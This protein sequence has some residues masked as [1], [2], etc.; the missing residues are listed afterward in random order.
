[1]ADRDT[2]RGLPPR[3]AGDDPRA[4]I[5]AGPAGC[6]KSTLGRALARRVGAALLDQDTLTNPLVAVVASLPGTDP[7]DLDAPPVRDR[8]RDARYD[9][10]LSVA[11]DNVDI[12]GSVVLVAPFT[13][14]T[15]EQDRWASLVR[16]LEPAEVVL[17]WVDCPGDLLWDRMAA[18]GAARDAGKLA[19]RAA[20]LAAL[21][22]PPRVRYVRVDATR[23]VDAQVAALLEAPTPGV[24][25]PAPRPRRPARR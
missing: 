18:R 5:V 2:V 25:A 12:G 7:D 13:G 10:L 1:V 11:R 23:S 4:W 14:E 22:G 21:P 16:R 19:D 24:R 15:R 20:F 8:T 3:P 17:V 9:A 6:G